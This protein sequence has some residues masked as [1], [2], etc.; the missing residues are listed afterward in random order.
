MEKVPTI[1]VTHRGWECFS[2][3]DLLCIGSSTLNG[4]LI[5]VRLWF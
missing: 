3:Y 4:L 2:G 1:G 5:G